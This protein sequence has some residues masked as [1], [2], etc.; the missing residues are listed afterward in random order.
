MSGDLPGGGGA[1]PWPDGY[2]LVTLDTVDSTMAEAQRRASALTGPTWIMAHAQTGA[3]GRQGRVWHQPPGNLAATLIWRPEATPAE[4][5][6]RSFMAAIAL[7]E[8]LAIWVDR[9][10]LG[11]KWPNDVLLD[12]GKVAGILLECASGGAYVDWLA[13]GIGV[14]LAAVPDGVG[15]PFPPAS[16]RAATNVEVDPLAFLTTLADAYATQEDKLRTFGFAR[17]REDW[18]RHAAR[19]G[20]D[21][22]VRVGSTDLHG[23]FDTIDADGNLILITPTGPRRIAQAEVFF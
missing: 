1:L 20:E 23:R 8:A 21:I 11:L 6:R 14:N 9:T 5:A 22:T 13:V 3:R 18:L 15:G 2:A 17:I 4:A 7:F 10:R 16:V 12:G 19:L